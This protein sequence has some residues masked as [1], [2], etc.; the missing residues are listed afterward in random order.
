MVMKRINN[1]FS[2]RYLCSKHEAKLY[3]T[4]LLHRQ[5]GTIEIWH[6]IISIAVTQEIYT[7]QIKK[8]TGLYENSNFKFI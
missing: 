8:M 7:A 6:R 3:G 4:K 5:K 2:N 1:S